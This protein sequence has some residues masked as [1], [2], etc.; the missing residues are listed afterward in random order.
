MRFKF[1]NKETTSFK[2]RFKYKVNA[3]VLRFGNSSFF[4]KKLQTSSLIIFHIFVKF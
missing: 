1:K 2:K 3:T 4:Y